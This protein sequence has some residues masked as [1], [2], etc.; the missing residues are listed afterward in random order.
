MP[1][2]PSVIPIS[3]HLLLEGKIFKV[4]FPFLS[5]HVFVVIDNHCPHLLVQV[6]L[7]E[8]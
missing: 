7:C 4:F 6:L 1:I 8:S 3:N 2:E 5:F